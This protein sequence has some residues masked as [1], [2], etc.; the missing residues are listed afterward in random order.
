MT[1]YEM[2]DRPHHRHIFAPSAPYVNAT[3]F[4][5]RP[6]RHHHHGVPMSSTLVTIT[7]PTTRTDGSALALTEI[8]SVILSKSVGSGGSAPVQTTDTPTAATVT[9][10]DNSPDFGQTDNYSATVTD[11]EGNVS[12]AGTVSVTIP[13]SA[14]AAPSAPTLTAV[15]TA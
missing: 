15:F 7:L 6:H 8:A 13:P 11:V 10:T 3:F 4:T 12:A 14:L 9:F 1:V 5:H 2:F